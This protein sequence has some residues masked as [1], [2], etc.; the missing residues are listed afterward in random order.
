[1][2][3][4][5]LAFLILVTITFFVYYIV[6][7]QFRECVLLVASCIFIGYFNLWFLAIAI[8]IS[9][10]TYLLGR[11]LEKENKRKSIA[12]LYSGSIVFLVGIWTFFRHNGLIIPLGISFY[13]FQALSYLTEIYWGEE[14]AE[15]DFWKFQLYMLLF[16][17]FLSGPIE[18]P[19]A[20]LPQLQTPKKFDYETITFGMRLILLGLIKKLVLADNLA[21]AIDGVFSNPQDYSGIQFVMAMLIYPIQLYADF[22]GYTDIA[23]G[24]GSLFGLKLSP[25][26]NRPFIAQ[27][28][29]D[30]W[31][32]WHMTL[33][34]W[35]RDYIFMP[36]TS[37]FRQ[38]GKTGIFISL[39]ITFGA[40]G[41]W[42]G[43]GM[44]YVVYGLI[45]GCI[46][47]YEMNV[48]VI[49]D[50]IIKFFGKKIGG[51]ILMLRTY[52]LFAFSLIFFRAGTM[53]SSLNFIKHLSFQTNSS[54]KEMNLGL[55]DHFCIITGIA[56]L[57]VLIF[58]HL[59]EKYDLLHITGKKTAWIR[60]ILYYTLIFALLTT[61]K[62]D[63][64]D[65]IY[66]QF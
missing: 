61:G 20:L 25:N 60:W 63:C 21:G 53:Q 1:M 39:L 18:R 24:T 42:H 10:I 66:L 26:F 64:N 44:S 54:W 55:S 9:S 15:K 32:R 8:G 13:S 36:V 28:T 33:S 50:S 17:K 14:K 12:W 5:S 16:A 35:V 52:L 2:E 23:I 7:K 22:S 58:E 37:A 38:W 29:A 49:R 27:T 56:F 65:F 43:V 34:F 45:Q 19:S 31:R 51:F 62:F 3:F 40:L 30:L 41:V 47:C 11:F 59:D 57:V 4:T 48:T 46:I 6:G